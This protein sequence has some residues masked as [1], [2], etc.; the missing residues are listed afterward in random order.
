LVFGV[1]IDI[2]GRRHLEN[3]L[4]QAQKMEA[5][6][7]LAGG[8]AHDFNNLLMGIQGRTSL[9]MMDT[10]PS[11]P[12]FEHLLG[13]EEY[14]KSA[15][16]LTKQLLGFARGGKYEVKPRDLNEIIG[17]SSE[18]FGRTRKEVVIHT[19]Y[20]EDL[21]TVEVDEG[22]IEQVLLNLFLNASQAMPGGGDLFIRTENVIL[23]EEYVMPYGVKA[24]RYVKS[25]VTDTGTGMDKGTMDRIFDP[26]FTTKGLGRGTGLGLP[27][28]YGIIKNHDGIIN[29]Y[30]E[31]G[32][33]TTFNIYLPA[34][35]KAV[36]KDMV[37]KEKLTRGS[38]RVLLVDDEEM[39]LDI[40]KKMIE[41]LGYSVMTAH[42]GRQALALYKEKPD[43]FNML[44]LD[45]IMP[46]M[47]G[48]ETFL[49]IKEVNPAV[50]VLLSSGYSLEGQAE[51]LLRLGC[52]SFIQ[53]PFNM[54]ELSEK[55][56]CVLDDDCI[57][58]V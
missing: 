55:I 7:T 38:E 12:Y 39:I 31:I 34:S 33:G 36:S 4:R 11:N 56:R 54:K 48:N 46:E 18:M 42:N 16:G 45:M 17:K 53:K 13:I 5:I 10:Q 28:T 49:A 30:S 50:K 47:S 15:T 22:Q 27:S 8:V 20:H 19:H 57:G 24:G 25:S 21:W 37:P 41:A 1:G 43:A 29:V 14:V 26:F 9:M 3:Q 2:T 58:P 44:I 35:S 6:G 52:K 32:Q 40:G 23:D 51:E